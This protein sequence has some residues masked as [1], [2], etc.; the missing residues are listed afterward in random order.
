MSL[1]DRLHKCNSGDHE[2]V[3]I[4]RSPGMDTDEVARW[5]R[6]CGAV[7][8]DYEYD[9]RLAGTSLKMMG[10]QVLRNVQLYYE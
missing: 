3:E 6:V 4:L 2:L 1:S 10:P 7:V 9:G 5:C 8:V